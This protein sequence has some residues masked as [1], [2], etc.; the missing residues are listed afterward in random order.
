MLHGPCGVA[1]YNSPCMVDNKYSKHFPKRFMERTTFDEQGYP[2]YRRR[3]DGRTILKNEVELDNRFV[4]Q[5]N[6]RLLLMFWAHLNVESCNQSR[7]IKYLF[8]Y[9]SKGHNQVTTTL[10]QSNNN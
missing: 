9:I 2:L 5:Y 4:V 8:K 10:Y 1:N 3:D 7:S 6:P